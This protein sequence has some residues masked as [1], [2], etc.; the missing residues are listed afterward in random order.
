MKV[1]VVDPSLMYEAAFA[2]VFP[3][4]AFFPRDG[5]P[6]DYVGSVRNLNDGGVSSVALMKSSHSSSTIRGHTDF[7]TPSIVFTRLF[8]LSLWHLPRVCDESEFDRIVWVTC[9]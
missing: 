9:T 4:T 5:V 6:L 8:H 7:L 3:Q 1:Y 2:H